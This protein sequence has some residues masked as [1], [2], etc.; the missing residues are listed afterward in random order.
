MQVF[1]WHG[2]FNKDHHRIHMAD[3]IDVQDVCCICFGTLDE[4]GE[5]K[6]DAVTCGNPRCVTWC[7]G[8]CFKESV[9][10]CQKERKVPQ[11]PG[12]NCQEL[13]LYSS[14]KT[15]KALREQYALGAFWQ[16]QDSEG[17]NVNR[18]LTEE[19]LTHKERQAK[20]EFVELK[21]P[22]AAALVAKIAFRP[23]LQ[24]I[25]RYRRETVKARIQRSSLR[26]PLMTCTGL[27]G[28]KTSDRITT[29]LLCDS[30]FCA[31]CEQ[32]LTESCSSHACDD[33]DLKSLEFIAGMVKCPGCNLPVQKDVGCNSITCANC[34]TNFLYTTGE[35]GGSGSQNAALPQ[36]NSVRLLSAV[37][38]ADKLP[39]NLLE[40]LLQLESLEPTEVSKNSILKLL[41]E[42]AREADPSSHLNKYAHKTAGALERYVVA[43]HRCKAYRNA[44]AKLEFALRTSDASDPS[45]QQALGQL[46]HKTVIAL[47]S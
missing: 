41:H 7:C 22:A 18:R 30:K 45:A 31:R 19:R 32:L 9:N 26:C 2:C 34:G 20:Y 24:R 8:S 44:M 16:M 23:K 6:A 21:F 15:D 13:Y 12:T 28:D 25:D 14:C 29:C 10:Y 35:R 27:L 5:E 39:P 36:T 11:C 1:L 17:D 40:Q 3:D 42:H 47:T 43:K 37:Y 4:L 46:M 38:G 33:A